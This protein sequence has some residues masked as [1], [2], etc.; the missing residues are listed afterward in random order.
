[1]KKYLWPI[2]FAA[3]C[4]AAYA[5][6]GDQGD[7]D[8]CHIHGNETM[9]AIVILNATSN[10]PAG[11]TGVAKIESE[12][13]D[14]NES[15]EIDLKTFGLVP[16]MYDL[17][18]TLQSSGTNIDLGQFIVSSNFDD[19]ENDDD[20]GELHLGVEVGAWV[21][22]N[23]GGFTNWGCWTNWSN[24]NFVSGGVWAKWFDHHGDDED[25]HGCGTNGIV[26][27]TKTD[28]PAGVNP[29]DIGEI[30]VSDTNGV[31]I[32]IGD[33]VNPAAGSVI[34]ISGTVQVSPGTNSTSALSGTAEVQS[35]A[36]KGKWQHHF[37][38]N[39]SGGTAKSNYKLSVNGKLKGAARTDKSGNV[40]VKK[41]P[42][43]T[44]ALRSLKLLDAQGN[45]AG[46]AQF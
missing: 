16:G 37:A 42:S 10:A 39:A 11:A 30:I 17:S 19:D 43:H 24:S 35:T 41:L 32:L 22:N 33:F 40:T 5:D 4:F 2:L 18:I 26:T 12:N 45:V 14:G 23:W 44:P 27:H 13:E 31:A 7:Q 25:N 9:D 21:S 46:S 29:T 15:A 8:E 38:L 1:M 28:L 36:S 3:L 20:Q 6:D 34:N